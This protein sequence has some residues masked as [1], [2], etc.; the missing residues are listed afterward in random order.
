MSG[1]TIVSKII[2]NM[3]TKNKF[4]VIVVP[5]LQDNYSYLLVDELTNKA[6]AIDSVEPE[7]VLSVAKSNNLTIESILTTH[8]HWDHAGGNKKMK[9]LLPNVPIYGGDDRVEAISNKVGD[10]DIINV[11]ELK[12]RVLFSPAHTSG[13][14]LYYVN[15]DDSSCVFTGDTLFIGGCGRLFEGSAAQMYHALYEVIGKLPNDTLVYCGHE[16]TYKNLLFAKTLEPHN[17]D[18]LEMLEFSEKQKEKGQPTVPSTVGLEKSFN[19]FMRV[20][21]DSTAAQQ[22]KRENPDAS[23]IDILG[24]KT[25]FKFKG[26]KVL[27]VKQL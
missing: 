7:K 4:K 5:V 18:L 16:Y 6:A 15:K 2:Q 23:P 11:G 13:H 3:V 12:V 10:N 24:Y 26:A 20:H 8:H 17:K 22:F 9:E 14:V 25:C 1:T 27:S 19:P 21:L